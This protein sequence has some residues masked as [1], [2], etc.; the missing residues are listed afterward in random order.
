[1]SGLFDPGWFS[2][3]PQFWSSDDHP[4]HPTADSPAAPPRSAFR[5]PPSKHTI[6]SHAAAVKGD[7]AQM[8]KV[9]GRKHTAGKAKGYNK[10]DSH[11]KEGA[12]KS[13]STATAS[14]PYPPSFF[15]DHFAS[16]P[17]NAPRRSTVP[18]PTSFEDSPFF[19]G[20]GAINRSAAEKEDSHS[21]S[22]SSVRSFVRPALADELEP[23]HHNQARDVSLSASSGFTSPAS[24]SSVSL[25]ST[26]FDYV[27]EDAYDSDADDADAEVEDE[28]LERPFPSPQR[29][30][31]EKYARRAADFGLYSPSPSA[32]SPELLPF[33]SREAPPST[34]PHKGKGK[35]L[36][37]ASSWADPSLLPP[38]LPPTSHLTH[39]SAAAAPLITPSTALATT[40]S[41][42][43][44]GLNQLHPNPSPPSPPAAALDAYYSPPPSALESPTD[45]FPRGRNPHPRLLWRSLLDKEALDVLDAHHDRVVGG[46]LPRLAVSPPGGVSKFGA[47]GI[48]RE[49]DHPGA[50][51]EGERGRSREERRFRAGGRG[52]REWSVEGRRWSK[53]VERCGL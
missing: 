30:K 52:R 48:E 21:A 15:E 31:Q 9:K 46:P 5:Q 40:S 51:E 20:A 34:K 7:S 32:S 39:P 42:K 47:S 13:A 36:A 1:M 50:R 26:E 23:L 6:A 44:H 41:N 16:S 38:I 14:S 8:P 12:A 3:L 11:A 10:K 2:S 43:L 27:S 49:R 29:A 33:D 19:P 4:S 24:G 18:L 53:E 22:S 28:D 17:L 37:A 35:A 45:R 25:A